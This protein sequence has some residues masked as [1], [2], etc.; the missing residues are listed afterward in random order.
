VRSDNGE[1]GF[2]CYK[3]AVVG[4][5]IPV[6]VGIVA[7]V[8]LA[9]KGDFSGNSWDLRFDFVLVTGVP[10]I[11][12]VA[13]GRMTRDFARSIIY[14]AVIF[15]VAADQVLCFCPWHSDGPKTGLVL[16][17][18]TVGGLCGGSGTMID[19]P[20]ATAGNDN[21]QPARVA[22]WRIGVLALLAAAIAVLLILFK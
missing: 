21:K 3:V 8:A 6:A 16:L 12:A 1:P 22:R 5:A 19:G 15:A 17:A 9:I 10:G 4:I 20:A 7:A 18:C 2:T 14:G 11:G 13:V